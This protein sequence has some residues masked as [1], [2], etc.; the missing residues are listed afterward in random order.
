V[1]GGY[2]ESVWSMVD[3][4]AGHFVRPNGESYVDALDTSACPG[5]GGNRVC[6]TRSVR[7]HWSSRMILLRKL[8]LRLRVPWVVVDDAA[9]PSGTDLAISVGAR[10]H[11]VRRSDREIGCPEYAGSHDI[12]AAHANSY[13][14]WRPQSRTLDAFREYSPTRPE[15]IASQNM[16]AD[17]RGGGS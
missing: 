17:D 3:Y 15:T 12:T 10:G 8:P 16:R 4:D 11:G 6:E 7:A 14:A 2:A 5:R 1:I 9:S 13:T